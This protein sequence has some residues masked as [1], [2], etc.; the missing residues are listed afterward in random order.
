[1]DQADLNQLPRFLCTS[2]GDYSRARQMLISDMFQMA[3]TP[4][5]NV[6]YEEVS[7]C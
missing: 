2:R 1:M 7:F 6:I 3:G 5:I 4:L